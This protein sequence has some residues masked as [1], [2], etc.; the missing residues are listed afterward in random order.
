MVRTL[1]AERF[2]GH[3][4]LAEE[5]RAPGDEVP[6]GY[7]WILDPLDG[8]TNYAHG[9]P[10]FCVLARARDRRPPR[11]RRRVRPGAARV[12]HRGA[13][14]GRRLNGQPLGCRGRDA[15]RRHAGDRLP[16]RRPRVA[17]RSGRASSARSSSARRPCAGWVGGARPVLRGG[18]AY[19]RVLG[20]TAESV[21]HGSRGAD[22]RGGGR[23]GAPGVDGAAF[24]CRA[25]HVL[26]ST[27]SCTTRW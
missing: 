22:R 23:P 9:L 7:C 27:A 20:A 10:F 3:R 26:A 11:A 1:V 16:V 14:T 2:P 24:D 25:G 13:G 18:R 15:D 21:G 6:G 4:V 12:V 5:L 19:G 17:R 8:T